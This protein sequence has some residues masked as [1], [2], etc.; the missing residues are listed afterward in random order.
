MPGYVRDVVVE[1]SATRTLGVKHDEALARYAKLIGCEV[2]D[3]Q[4]DHDPALQN[5]PQFRM[6]GQTHYRPAAN[7]PEHLFYRPHGPQFDRSHK[8][9]TLVRG[10]HGQHSD[11]GL[12]RKNKRIAKNRAKTSG[13]SRLKR[14]GH[15]GIKSK[16]SRPIRGAN[17][18]PPKG[19]RKIQNRKVRR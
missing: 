1:A 2:T 7:D 19:S 12:A 16:V 4:L 3:L 6:N 14:G 10:D 17:R 18:W 13:D 9:K 5:R 11:A 15:S 8:I